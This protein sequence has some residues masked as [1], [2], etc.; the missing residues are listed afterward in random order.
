MNIGNYFVHPEK[1]FPTMSST[2]RLQRAALVFL[3]PPVSSTKSSKTLQGLARLNGANHVC[4]FPSCMRESSNVSL[5]NMTEHRKRGASL[6][7]EDYH[8]LQSNNMYDLR[9]FLNA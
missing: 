3:P 1:K 9:K 6:I 7:K 2:E 8:L 5:D 4:E